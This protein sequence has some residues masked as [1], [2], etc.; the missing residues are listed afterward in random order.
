MQRRRTQCL[1]S[2]QG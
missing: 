1:L 2:L